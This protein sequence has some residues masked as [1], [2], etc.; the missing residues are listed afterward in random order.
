MRTIFPNGVIEVF[1]SRERTDGSNGST[2]FRLFRGRRADFEREPWTR[3][4]L[5]GSVVTDLAEFAGWKVTDRTIMPLPDSMAELRVDIEKDLTAEG[6]G[7]SEITEA[8][9]SPEYDFPDGGGG[10]AKRT[11]YGPKASLV[12]DAWMARG[13]VPADMPGY[14]IRKRHVTGP[15]GAATAEVDLSTALA[16]SV[17]DTST[18]TLELEY[19]ESQES[20]RLHPEFAALSTAQIIQATDFVAG[21]STTWD[22]VDYDEGDSE[23][24]KAQ[25]KLARLLIAGRDTMSVWLPVVRQTVPLA[26]PPVQG[27]GD[28]T[29]LEGFTAGTQQLP[30]IRVKRP[31]GGE[32]YW[33]RCQDK[34]ARGDSGRWFNVMEWRASI[35][36]PNLAAEALVE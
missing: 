12:A 14:R 11:F 21:D 36:I 18:S 33:T 30:P 16:A 9:F 17:D 28:P 8:D 22:N 10:T 5:R 3:M 15:A 6:S 27:T 34:L 13:T 25:K 31:D 20:I 35:S 1:G 29:L 4:F 32:Y 26:A 24:V 7:S 23:V 19:Q 2:S